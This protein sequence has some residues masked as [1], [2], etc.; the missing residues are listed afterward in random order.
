MTTSSSM[1]VKALFAIILHYE[2][3]FNCIRPFGGLSLAE[4]QGEIFRQM[5]GAV[6]SQLPPC[7]QVSPL[8][9]IKIS[10]GSIGLRLSLCSA[11]AFTTLSSF[12]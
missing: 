7:F 11:M 6:A 10:A 9:N 4:G 5:S 3:Q 1:R 8:F 2:M 12:S